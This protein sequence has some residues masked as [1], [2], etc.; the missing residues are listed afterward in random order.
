M[1]KLTRL[2]AKITN[3]FLLLYE[4]AYLYKLN[5][6]DVG[7]FGVLA[8]LGRAFEAMASSCRCCS[9]SRITLYALVFVLATPQYARWFAYL[10]LAGFVVSA[11]YQYYLSYRAKQWRFA[12]A[13]P[14]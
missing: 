13:T 10:L 4:N 14:V 7:S 2:W 3:A 11:L 9:G 12:Y 1:D 6:C 8:P 5:P